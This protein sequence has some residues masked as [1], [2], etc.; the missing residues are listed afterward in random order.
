MRLVLVCSLV[1]GLGLGAA[2]ADDEA[3]RPKPPPA[4][5]DAQVAPAL[6][7]FK[8]DFA[9]TDM[10]KRLKAVR[11]LGRWRHKDVLKEL[12][13]LL[14][15]ESDLE[16]KAAAA[17]GFGHQTTFASDAARALAEFLKQNDKLAS[18]LAPQDAAE[19]ERIKYESRVLVA[20]WNS[21]GMLGWKDAWKDWKGY[22]DH[23]HDDV[24]SA[25]IRA[26]GA[27]KEYRSLAPLLEWF[28]IYPDGVSWEGGSVSVDTGAAGGEDQAAAE[29]AW[30]AKYGGRAK[31]ARPAIVDALLKTVKEIT[32]QEFSKPAQLK[33]WMED[34]KLLLR[35]HGA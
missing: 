23:A 19:E 9:E 24:A 10:D 31:K 26:F 27:L 28:N 18:S 30:R 8:R 16:I 2:R 17:E 34:N 20:C 33:Q 13:R 14:R 5:T 21:V 11:S 6:A 12:K 1:F 25:A 4:H 32:G 29:A 3:E 7:A 22:I 15:S 35:K